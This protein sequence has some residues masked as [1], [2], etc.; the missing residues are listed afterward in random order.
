MPEAAADGEAAQVPGAKDLLRPEMQDRGQAMPAQEEGMM[1][2]ELLR[3]QTEIVPVDYDCGETF[4]QCIDRRPDVFRV[5]GHAVTY[6]GPEPM[7]SLRALD[8]GQAAS[9]SALRRFARGG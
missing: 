4:D 8:N 3:G 1:I 9:Q 7:I 5:D 2:R 6:I